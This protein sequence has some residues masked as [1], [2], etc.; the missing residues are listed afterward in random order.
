MKKYQTNVMHILFNQLKHNSS[1]GSGSGLFE[2]P[3]PELIAC[4]TGYVKI[5]VEVED[6]VETQ[7][8]KIKMRER[9]SGR[10]VTIHKC[11]TTEMSVHYSR[12]ARI[13]EAAS[14]DAEAVFM[15]ESILLNGEWINRD[16][17]VIKLLEQIRLK[18]ATDD[19]GDLPDLVSYA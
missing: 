11:H 7:V 3:E 8:W 14:Y 16:R 1:S 15:I 18:Q 5:A 6:A 12:V 17:G 2:I 9:Q 10:C 19:R 13:V 4:T